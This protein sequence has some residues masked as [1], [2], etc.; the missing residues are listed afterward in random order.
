MNA[1]ALTFWLIQINII[2]DQRWIQQCTEGFPT[3]LEP[4]MSS[5]G[6]RRDSPTSILIPEMNFS[7]DSTIMSVEVVGKKNDNDNMRYPRLQVWREDKYEQGIYYKVKDSDIVLNPSA[8]TCKS[9][10]MN[11]RGKTIFNYTQAG[12]KINSGDILGLR[13][14]PSSMSGFKI[15]FTQSSPALN[16]YVYV[17]SNAGPLCV[18]LSDESSMKVQH[19]QPLIKLQGTYM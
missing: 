17:G 7:C 11:C 9:V 19:V 2:I 14:P 6:P 12:I 10:S 1:L 16:S 13:L 4:M 8:A 3:M 5:S 15:L 18:N